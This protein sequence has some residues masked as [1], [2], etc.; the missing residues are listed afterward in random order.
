MTM[1]HPDGE[2][3]FFNDSAIGIAASPSNLYSYCDRL[4][5]SLSKS[6]DP[7]KYLA[8]SGYVRVEMGVAVLLVDVARIGPDYIPGHAHADTLS[9]E[10][11]IDGRRV[12]VNS[13]TSQYGLGPEREWERSTAAHNTIEIDGESSSEVWGGFRVARRGYPL[14]I[15]IRRMGTSVIIEACHDGYMRL[16]RRAL[17]RRRWTIDPN[18][19]EVYDKIEGGFDQAISRIYLHPDAQIEINGTEGRIYCRGGFINWKSTFSDLAIEN[20]F[21]HPA[22]GVSEPNRCIKMSLEPTENT[23]TGIF[24]INWA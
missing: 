18:R 22:F 21:W 23:S 6:D 12:I 17:H 24:A 13:G 7:V 4:G 19:L 20:T 14:D 11:S 8:D 10:L 2:V 3:S 15:S 1:A 9:Y 16:P 5:I